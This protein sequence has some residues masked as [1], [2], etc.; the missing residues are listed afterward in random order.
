VLWLRA[1]APGRWALALTPAADQPQL[2]REFQLRA[3]GFHAFEVDLDRVVPRLLV[4]MDGAPVAE[5]SR[6]LVRLD[7]RTVELG[8]GPRGHGAPDFGQ[9]SGTLLSE[10]F[11]AAAAPGLESAPAI[12]TRPAVYSP[13]GVSP[14]AD[15]PLG[16][17]WVPAEEQG[18]YLFCASGW[19]W[20]PRYA[21]DRVALE[22]SLPPGDAGRGV[23]PVFFS[24]SSAAAD[25]VFVRHLGGGRCAFGV[26]RWDGQRWLFQ[27]VGPVQPASPQARA[28]RVTLDRPAGLVLVELDGAVA[29]RSTLALAPILR[30][31]LRLVPPAGAEFPVFSSASVPR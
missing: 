18:A 13:V 21:L 5:M 8:R 26:A 14:P 30:A 22:S 10:P 28:L 6:A 29:L 25:A 19:R 17:L 24:G 20:V 23:E 12:S 9:F 16:Q 7:K 2:C 1:V 4:R 27:P 11:L 15:P 3:N 31:G